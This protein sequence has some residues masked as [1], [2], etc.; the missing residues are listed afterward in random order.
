VW[1]TQGCRSGGDV[2]G[3]RPQPVRCEGEVESGEKPFQ[4]DHAFH[5]GQR[6]AGAVLHAMPDG[7]VPDG[8]GAGDFEPVGGRPVRVGV[9]SRGGEAGIAPSRQAVQLTGSLAKTTGLPR[10]EV[11]AAWR[12][13]AHAAASPGS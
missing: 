7:Q 3:H 2:G 6:C 1:V 11:S 9:T 10:T 5:P 12:V 13:T 8:L 4:G